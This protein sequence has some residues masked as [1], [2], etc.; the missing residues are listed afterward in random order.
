MGLTYSND[1][2]KNASKY[3]GHR[4]LNHPISNNIQ[5][6]NNQSQIVKFETRLFVGITKE[7]VLISARSYL[8]LV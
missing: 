5:I 2:L 1:I 8:S 6:T 3:R 4:F 7:H